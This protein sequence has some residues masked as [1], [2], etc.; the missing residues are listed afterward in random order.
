MGAPASC[1]QRVD[2]GIGVHA[3]PTDVS[4]D[5]QASRTSVSE[6]ITNTVGGHRMSDL[7]DDT[8]T[9]QRTCHR[10]SCFTR[11]EPTRVWSALTEASEIGTYLYGLAAHSTWQADAPIHL[12]TADGCSLTGQVLHVQAPSRLSYTLQSGAHDPAVYLTWHIRASVAGS[13]ITLQVDEL[14]SCPGDEEAE[15]I[16]LPVLAALQQTLANC[17]RT[18]GTTVKT[19]SA[20]HAR[21]QSEPP[22]PGPDR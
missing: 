5:T 15:D 7:G 10:F 6:F 16:W 14:D 11:A 13:A 1:R 8:R 20:E 12:E 9:S 3:S 18:N 4:G 17:T 22:G 21:D 2:L 19:V